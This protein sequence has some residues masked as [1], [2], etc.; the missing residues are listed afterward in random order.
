MPDPVLSQRADIALSN[1]TNQGGML[2]VEQA[3]SFID[4][5]IDQPTVL[6]DCRTVTMSG[7]TMEINRIGFMNRILHAATQAISTTTDPWPPERR[8]TA[9]QRSQPNLDRLTLSTKEVI[10]EVNIPYEV[11]EDNIERG[12]MENTIL[13]L[14][15]ARAALDL[16]ELAIQGDTT[17]GDSYLALQDGFLK[18]FTSNVVDQGGQ[19]IDAEMFNRSIKALP[20]RYRRNKNI[21]RFYPS[22]NVEQDYR[23]KLSSRG[24]SLGDDILTGNRDVPVFGIPMKGV[25]LM[26]DGN[27]LL[28]NPQNL[29]FGIQRSIR[30]ES[31]RMIRD[32][33]VVIVLTARIALQVEDKLAG[34]KVINIGETVPSQVSI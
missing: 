30:I 4:M 28:T 9:T 10:A 17:S 15:A 7:P 24:T 23:M 13:R 29:I 27:C 18:Y 20:T 14:I 32:R 3:N 5:V 21:L 33:M 6:K 12:G 22:S 11:L 1:L 16:E 25:A 8:L 31:D 26:P 19:A 34:V 2:T